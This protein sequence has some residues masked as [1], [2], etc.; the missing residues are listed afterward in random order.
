MLKNIMVGCDG[1][2]LFEAGKIAG[3]YVKKKV[4]KSYEP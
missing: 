4:P 1:V 2:V 3:N